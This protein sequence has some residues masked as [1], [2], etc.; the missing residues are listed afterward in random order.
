MDNI[1]VKIFINIIV[2]NQL[3]S[4]ENISKF[5]DKIRNTSNVSQ[6]A[7]I[8]FLRANKIFQLKNKEISETPVQYFFEFIQNNANTLHDDKEQFF[9]DFLE[10]FVLKAS[11][12]LFNDEI[13]E[14]IRILQKIF[15]EEKRYMSRKGYIKRF[16]KYKRIGKIKTSLSIRK[17]TENL[18][19]LYKYSYI[20]PSYG[21]LYQNLQADFIF[22]H[23]K[24]HPQISQKIIKSLIE[25][26]PFVTSVRTHDSTFSSEL[27]GF[28]F[29]PN[30]YIKDV[31]KIIRLLQERGIVIKN[32]VFEVKRYSNTVN[33]NYFREYHHRKRCLTDPHNKNYDPS[34]E[35]SYKADFTRKKD[36]Y[37]LNLLE[38]VILDRAWRWAYVGFSFESLKKL[39][40]QLRKD[41]FDYMIQQK[42]FISNLRGNL[43]TI[44]NDS[45][46][47]SNFST[48][49]E[50]YEKAGFFYLLIFLSDLIYISEHLFAYMED[51]NV[52]SIHK[53]QK[54]IQAGTFFCEI[55]DFNRFNSK[56]I[57]KALRKHLLPLYFKDPEQLDNLL[58]D[59][60]IIV[61]FLQ[62][63]KELK[64]FDIKTIRKIISNEKL[65]NIVL[66]SKEDKFTKMVKDKERTPI[67]IEKINQIITKFL[68]VKVIKPLML[69]TLNT[70][71]FAVNYFLLLLRSSAKN[72]K[73]ILQLKQ[74][75]PRFI[76]RKVE[77]LNTEKRYIK[78]IFYFPA[79][80]PGEKQE[81]ISILM[82]IFGKDLLEIKPFFSSGFIEHFSLLDY[83]DLEKGE[84]FYTKDL[85]EQFNAYVSKILKDI[86]VP[87]ITPFK[88]TYPNLLIGKEKL[89]SDLANKISSNA[90][91]DTLKLDK[92][93]LNQ[94]IKD[95]Y[96]F[97]KYLQDR[98]LLSQ[99][100]QSNIY[101][102]YIKGIN[103]KINYQKF[104]LSNYYLYIQP[105]FYKALD[106]DFKID[107]RHLLQN[108]FEYIKAPI[109][110][111]H[112][113]PLL[114]SFIFPYRTPNDK[115]IKWLAKSKKQLLGYYLY[116]IKKIHF[117]L[118]FEYNLGPEGWS[119]NA[120]HFRSFVHHILF[121]P[122]FK[123]KPRF[124]T[125]DIGACPSNKIFSPNSRQFKTLS[126]LYKQKQKKEIKKTDFLNKIR[127][128]SK[129]KLVYP[130]LSLKNLG[131]DHTY[132]IIIPHV[133]RDDKE[134]LLKI[135]SYFNHSRI[136]E[137]EGESFLHGKDIESF[138][139]G[140]V[141]KLYL[142]ALEFSPFQTF[143]HEVFEYFGFNNFLILK[144]IAKLSG[145][146]K[147]L[148]DLSELE[149]YNP[150]GNLQWSEL[151]KKWLN[152]K[153]YDEE[154]NKKFPPLNPKMDE[155]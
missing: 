54:K 49:L 17:F 135:F 52:K 22:F 155:M 117:N 51:N 151:D 125:F 81:L 40:N 90:T 10:N 110:A 18:K 36:I 14:T 39:L 38:S 19:W 119:Y 27:L 91:A 30:N 5:R 107:L 23:L 2:E 74:Y 83:Y 21:F 64:I 92:P 35:L 109:M 140:L 145:F 75:F 147:S 114:I 13:V 56:P 112:D 3:D 68:K 32:H 9:E 153:L 118:H 8:Y 71:S 99:F 113:I 84:Y 15:Y 43:L 11:K 111:D 106:D 141:I 122:Q 20:G 77:G 121:E 48:I 120:K 12:N 134:R 7:E 80:N 133:R 93:Q 123:I 146:I 150:L 33:L 108:T 78:S 53:V 104:G 1:K 126:A 129:E 116:F 144:D 63:C 58:R 42:S 46:L 96:S 4:H 124:K 127:S 88:G 94:L 152:W 95:Y 50:K 128:L 57:K 24:F 105:L 101:K 44:V 142:P 47:F 139:L 115:N 45:D 29:I 100:Q 103:F 136:Y 132:L 97:E 130:Y 86:S 137:I 70:T 28:L 65:A 138:E 149:E 26:M 79:L 76:I 154:F 6:L 60:K 66:D 16:S 25:N 131:L 59:Y 31:T 55:E 73:K 85:F 67:N 37:E 69:T 34:Y 143:F 72:E 98:D 148:Y 62:N 89:I 82:N 87:R 102:T 61:N 41:I